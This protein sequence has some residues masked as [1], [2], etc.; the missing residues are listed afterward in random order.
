M[1]NQKISFEFFPVQTLEG[2]KNLSIV[3]KQLSQYNP[4]F[5]SCTSGAGGSTKEGTLQIIKDI[6]N[7]NLIAKPHL[8]CI[9]TSKELITDMVDEYLDLE[10]NQVLALRGD[11]PSG[12]PIS[13]DFNYASNLVEFL[14]NK[15]Q[16]KLHITVAAYPEFHPQSKSANDDIKNFIKK[17][18][19][20]ADC[21]IT[22]YFYNIDAYLHF[23]EEV[24]ASGIDIP[25]I[26]GIM[27]I[28]SFTN[29]NRFSN[30]CKAEIP[31]WLKLK[32]QSL[33]DDSASIRS[34]GLDVVTELCYKLLEQG[35]PGLHFY[36]LNKAGIVSTI[37]ERLG[38]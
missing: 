25:I 17:C 6:L 19:A 22:Q 34:L 23:V 10:V 32:L 1:N 33:I 8:S 12:M 27:P 20:G 38:Y 30:I 15:Y 4:E 24:K 7:D 37:C 29:L 13:N 3:R 16:N 9:A 11:I 28:Y 2:R 26:P 5:F 21:A 35:A 31:R 14:K 36:T 18:K